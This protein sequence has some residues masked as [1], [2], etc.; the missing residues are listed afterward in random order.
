MLLG[1][2]RVYRIESAVF[3]LLALLLPT[4]IADVAGERRTISAPRHVALF[5]VLFSVFLLGIISLPLLTFPFL[6][7][8]FV[9]L[10]LYR[11][12]TDLGQAPQFF[13]PLFAVVFWALARVGDESTLPF[14]LASLLLHLGS[15]YFVYKVSRRIFDS[16]GPAILCFTIF[17]LNPVQPEVVLWASGLQDSLWTFFVLAA[18]WYYLEAGTLSPARAAWTMVLLWCALLAKETAICFVLILPAADCL[19]YRLRRG[20][21]LPK[22]YA[23]FVGELIAY[24]VVRHHFVA[25]E[26]SYFVEPS[27]YFVK[28]FLTTPYRVFVQ[29]WNV[30]A[31]HMWPAIACLATLGILLLLFYAIVFKRPGARVLAGPFVILSSTLPAYSY[32][33]VSSD[34]MASRYLYFAAFGWALLLTELVVRA[35]RGYR[36]LAAATIFVALTS[37]ALLQVNLRPWRIA[38]D[39]VTA[40]AAGLGRGEP[41]A[42]ILDEWRRAHDVRLT[43]ERG[44]PRS[45]QGVGI[46]INGYSEFL[47]FVQRA[48]LK[49]HTT[50]PH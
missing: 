22:A 28:Q 49:D 13:R 29:P 17:L 39:V 6:S 5:V 30:S 3:V 44:I 31:I 20:P 34:L 41:S 26:S 11:Q 27:R 46:F 12:I 24:L 36:T 15:A 19:L 40:L 32:F 23:L 48:E 4:V 16:N 50:V 7:D 1:G 45:Y 47:Q 25:M 33:Y 43:P 18:T 37:A 35:T 9:F 21:F 10:G 38:G 2:E 14:H 42:A 8:D